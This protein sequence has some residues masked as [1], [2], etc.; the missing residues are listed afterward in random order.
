M[1]EL[2]LCVS[3]AREIP[4]VKGRC[5]LCFVG[6]KR[7][8]TPKLPEA[9]GSTHTEGLHMAHRVEQVMGYGD[10]QRTALYLAQRAAGLRAAGV[11]AGERDRALSQHAARSAASACDPLCIGRGRDRVGLRNAIP[12]P[13]DAPT[14][15]QPTDKR[16]S[17]A[18]SIDHRTAQQQRI[19]R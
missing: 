18:D 7:R 14:A 6:C 4:R 10:R 13:T 17:G 9:T 11:K 1:G 2:W 3:A 5:S 16:K 12:R 19:E 15:A 8:L